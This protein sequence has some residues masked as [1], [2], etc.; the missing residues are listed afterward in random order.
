MPPLYSGS[1][2]MGSRDLQP[3]GH[4]RRVENML[5]TGKRKKLFYLSIDFL[6]EK[7][8]TPKQEMYQQTIEESYPHVRELAVRGSENPNLMPEGRHHGAL[9]LGRRLG[10]HHHRQEPGDDAVRPA[11]LPHQGQ[12]EVRLGEEGQPTTYYLSAAPEPIRINCE[13]FYVDVVL[14]PDPNVFSHTNALAGLKEGG[15]F[16]IQSD[17]PTPRRSGQSIPPP[18]QKIIATRRSGLRARRV[19]DRARR[20]HRP[21]AAAAHAGHRLPGRLLRRVAA[22]GT[23]RAR[24]ETLLAGDPRPAA[25]QVRR[26]GRARGRGQHARRQARL[27]RAVRV[28][29]GEIS[30]REGAA[31]RRRQR[32]ADP[33]DG[34]SGCRR[35]RR[36]SAT[37]TASGSRPA[38]S[39]LAAWATTT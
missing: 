23:G 2:G 11:R 39:T 17:Q 4:R 32:A 14:S 3:E 18:F 13:Y 36:R 24:R 34:A 27:R 30:R 37:S 19:Q 33:G 22:H 10:R 15:V 8:L 16:I 5:P 1:F 28:E 35:A 7:A 29:P 9:P 25:G 31:T 6:R 12:P 21:R 26:Q 20:G 38:T